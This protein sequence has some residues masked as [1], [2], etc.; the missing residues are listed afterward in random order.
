M[1]SHLPRF[2]AIESADKIGYLSYI[3]EGGKADG[4]LRFMEAEVTS[5]F[6]KFEVE[7][8]KTR[9]LVHIRSCQNNKYW[10]RT[11]LLP[12]PSGP[13]IATTAKKNEDDQ[14]KVECTLFRFIPVDSATN[15][16]RIMHVQSGHYVCPW[17][18]EDPKFDHGLLSPHDRFDGQNADVFTITDWSLLLI[19]PRYVA[20]KGDNDKYLYQLRDEL[21]IFSQDDVGEPTVACEIL[22]TKDGNIRIKALKNE[23]FFRCDSKWIWADTKDAT[24]EGTLFHPVKV[25]DDKIALINLRNNNFSRRLSG[26]GIGD[27]FAAVISSVTKEAQITVEEAVLTRQIYDVRYDFDNSRVYGEAVVVVDRNSATNF[28]DDP[29]TMDVKLSYKDTKTSSWKT[30]ISVTLGMKTT[31]KFEVPLIAEGSVELSAEMRT[32]VEWGKVFETTTDLEVVQKVVVPPMTRVT[33]NLIATKG[34][35]D[36]PFTY[37]QRDT[38]YDGRSV[39]TEVEGGTYFGSNYHSMKFETRAEKLSSDSIK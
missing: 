18:T 20:F 10:Q 33:V 3:R 32:G 39:V 9:G 23:K 37:M 28:T 22:P 38:L 2:I 5:P 15:K 1:A 26:D 21:L 31:M 8:S 13:W 17:R 19:L 12:V 16:F 14:S 35:C 36:V 27:R 29:S 30:D 7:S 4:Y 34:L 24:V 6:A 25:G 11:N